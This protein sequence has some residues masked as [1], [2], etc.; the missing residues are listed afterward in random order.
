MATLVYCGRA[1][2]A[3]MDLPKGPPPVHPTI[4]WRTLAPQEADRRILLDHKVEAVLQQAD[5]SAESA[6]IS[7]SVEV[8]RRG[9]MEEEMPTTS[10]EISLI[11]LRKAMAD[12]AMDED[13]L[14]LVRAPDVKGCWWS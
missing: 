14:Q 7:R 5:R 2:L 12:A 9:S 6:M 10:D 4:H 8:V 11:Y 13:Q 1:K 3:N